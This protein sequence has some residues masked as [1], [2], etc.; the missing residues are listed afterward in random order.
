M[1]ATKFLSLMSK[2]WISEIY[3]SNDL[4][5]ARFLYF[6]TFPSGGGGGRCDP[7]WRLETKRRRA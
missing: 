7:P 1:S 3:Q 4:T 6:A 2:I 5:L